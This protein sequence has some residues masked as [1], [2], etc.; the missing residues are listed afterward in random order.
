MASLSQ[1]LPLPVEMPDKYF[2]MVEVGKNETTTECCI[3]GSNCHDAVDQRHWS[4]AIDERWQS[5]C[6]HISIG[7]K[8]I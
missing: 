2:S 3:V 5:L 7:V 6:R 8:R 1:F 4:S